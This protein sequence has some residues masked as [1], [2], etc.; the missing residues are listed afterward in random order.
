[1]A[2]FQTNCLLNGK[3]TIN[4]RGF[5]MIDLFSK[6]SNILL[7]QNRREYARIF[8]D[9]SFYIITKSTTHTRLGFRINYTAARGNYTVKPK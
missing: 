1:M 4:I 7:L 2:H 3:P 6:F 5:S 9:Q 8:Q